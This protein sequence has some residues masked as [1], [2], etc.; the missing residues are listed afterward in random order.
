MP[1]EVGCFPT[2]RFNDKLSNAAKFKLL[3]TLA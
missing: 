3:P 1:N 2:F